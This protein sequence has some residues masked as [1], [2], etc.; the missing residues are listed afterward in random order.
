[1]R[2]H[3][4][5]IEDDC[6]RCHGDTPRER[7]DH[8]RRSR[9]DLTVYHESARCAQCHGDGRDFS[10]LDPRCSVCHEVDWQPEAFDHARTGTALDEQHEGI[11]CT[12]CH[13]EGFGEPATCDACHEKTPKRVRGT[14]QK[15]ANETH[16]SPDQRKGAGRPGSNG[17]AFAAS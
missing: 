17:S 13:S 8:A 1:V 3:R 14:N 2:C 16:E 9:F 12:E 7:F 4:E 10:G 15:E 5:E 11:A 6:E